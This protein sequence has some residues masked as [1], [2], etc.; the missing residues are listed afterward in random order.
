MKKLKLLFAAFMATCGLSVNAADKVV[1]DR[2]TSIEDLDGKLFAVVDE[3]TST[4]MG[5]GI[6]GHGNVWDMYFGT[7][8]EAYASNACYLKIETASDGYCYLHTYDSA[9]NLFNTS[10]ASGGYFNSQKANLN[11]CFA[12]G[13]DQDGAD[14]SVWSIQVSEGKFALKNK[15]TGLYL[16][17]DNK[18]A[19]Y[20]DPFY[21]T[22]CTLIEDPLPAA[23]EK[24]T[25]LKA[26]YLAIKSTLDVTDADNLYSSA[27]TIE[28]VQNAIDA[29]I[30]IFGTSLEDGANLTSLITNPSFESDGLSGWANNGMAA[31]GNKVFG[32]TVGN[33]YCE[34]WQ[35]NG[36]K[37]VS[38]TVT[39]LPKGLYQLSANSLARGV[40]SAKLY[41]NSKEKA[42]KIV[43]ASNA[44][45]FDFY[46]SSNGDAA[47]GFEGVGTGAGDSWICVDNFQ[48]TY[49]QDMT[50]EEY[51]A[52]EAY[53][54]ALDAYNDAFAAAQ[55]LS[56][57]I[58]TAAY[59]LV[60]QAISNNTVTDGTTEQY[61]TAATNLNTAVASAQTLS[62]PYATWLSLKANA[63]ALATGHATLTA[64]VNKVVLYVETLTTVADLTT[65]NTMTTA[66]IKNYSA[67]DE[68]KNS[69]DALV[70]VSNN[71]SSAN[72]D[73]AGVITTQDNNIRNAAVDTQADITTLINVTIP[74]ATATLKAKMIEY[75]TTVQPTNDECFDLTFLIVNP[76]FTEGEG[77]W[78]KVASGWTLESGSVTEHRLQT[79]NFEAYHTPFNLSQTIKDLPKGTYKV[80]L[81]GFARHDD[82][83]VTDKTNLYCGIVNQQIK[84]IKAEYSTTSYY[85]NAQTAMGDNN[86]DTKYTKDDVDV[87]QPNGMTGAYYWFQE[88]NPAT[89]QPFY[90][91]EV[92]TLVPTAGDLKIGFK[93]ETNTDWV[94]WDNFHLYYYGSA[95]EVTID[96]DQPISFSEDVENAN[97]TL[98]RTIKAGNWNTIA[99]P[100][101]LSDAETTAAFGSDAQVATCTETP[102]GNNSII[103]FNVAAD[104]A[105]TANVPVLLKTSTAGT[106]YSFDA[107]TIKAGE[108]KQEGTNFDFVGTYAALTTI[109]EGDY[110][111]GSNQLWK[112]TGATT[113]K[114]TRAYLKAKTAGARIANFL[115]DGDE[116]T[117]IQTVNA[118]AQK[119][120]KLYNMNGQ[121]VKK[122]AKGLYIKNGK[123]M[124]VK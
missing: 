30:S 84:D 31:Q 107:K 92:E 113:I 5:F 87:Y 101:D 71:N 60:Q 16:H 103:A 118:K 25:T 33:I 80:T 50:D 29:L 123:K 11:V 24:Y 114:G 51:S 66:M 49:I 12:L 4:A 95:I 94:I 72:A 14:L 38:Q 119:S 43:D 41:A 91:N 20:E 63:L 122:A 74:T 8:N 96:E 13:K 3:S 36:T 19:K 112:S 1:G 97:I 48:L 86:R 37:S 27:T 39:G 10:W 18:P 28:G 115:I 56:G 35:P 104:A 90:T 121:E 57:K 83:N 40:T 45:S 2:F 44:Y 67:W 62:T 75:V 61:N 81:Q 76:H 85:S 15:G 120:E 9:G 59:A 109:A 58:P 22:F 17:N 23:Q 77:G 7:Y 88:V 93:C 82:A 65:V 98:K 55:A 73:L 34:A 52:Y 111:I 117:G 68:L 116:A 78:G 105:I 79:H 32:G 124:V 42:I 53:H 6:P 99:L 70:A 26:K 89:S 64:A 110:F 102:N 69:A 106:S 46:L 100:F 21:F 54:V 47:I 108:A